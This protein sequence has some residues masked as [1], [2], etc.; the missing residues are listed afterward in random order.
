M[1]VGF[2]GSQKGMTPDQIKTVMEIVEGLPEEVTLHHGDC[3]GSDHQMHVMVDTLKPGSL[4]HIH[5]PLDESKAVGLDGDFKARPKE[6]LKRNQDIVGAAE[7][8][9]ATPDGFKEKGR[10][11]GTWYT[12]RHSRKTSTPIIVVYPDGSKGA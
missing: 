3:I 1:D 2:T 9:I 11:S 4:K 12:I 5:P 6:Y 7:L 10:G 8:M